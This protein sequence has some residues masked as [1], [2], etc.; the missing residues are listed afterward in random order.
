MKITETVGRRIYWMGINKMLSGVVQSI[1]VLEDY[2]TGSTTR[3]CSVLLGNGKFV[4]V[5]ARSIRK[6]D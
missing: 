3:V 5:Q 2:K 4:E 1:R 6:V